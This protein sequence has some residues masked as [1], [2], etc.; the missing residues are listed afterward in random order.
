[1]DWKCQHL[2]D[3]HF[4]GVKYRAELFTPWAVFSSGISSCRVSV[5]RVEM[6]LEDK[7]LMQNQFTPCYFWEI[8]GWLKNNGINLVLQYI[9]QCLYNRIP[10]PSLSTFS[11]Y[12]WSMHITQGNT[13]IGQQFQTI[14]VI[15]IPHKH[16]WLYSCVLYKFGTIT[17]ITIQLSG[18]G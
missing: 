6:L 11:S 15:F 2:T 14:W 7:Q 8:E 1:M 9:Y 17:S 18:F 16:D 3:L 4:W 10:P 12:K 5:L 13:I